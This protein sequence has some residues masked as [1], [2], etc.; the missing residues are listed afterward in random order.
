MKLKNLILLGVL[1]LPLFACDDA[2]TDY[3]TETKLI[4]DIPT[5][6]YLANPSE[7][8]ETYHFDGTGIFC[9]GYSDELKKCPGD[10]VQINPGVGSTI[11]FETLQ[12]D[13]TIKELQLVISYKTQ[14]DDDYQQ[15]HS[16]DL[17]Q[18]GNL[19][20]S[21]THT[22]ELDDV[23]APLI[24]RLN[25]NPRYLISIEI[26]GLANFNLSSNAQFAIPLIIESEYN[27]PRFT[28]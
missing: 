25:E 24:N 3:K 27:S 7:S 13:E 28:L 17:L 2:N 8:L 20:S 22:L 9:L 1:L 6:S 23:L 18:A 5:K 21:D 19:L 15:I 12:N 4:V 16:V 10:I 14:G 11:S 26:K